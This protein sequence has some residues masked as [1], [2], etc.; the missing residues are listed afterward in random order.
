MMNGHNNQ[1]GNGHI[2]PSIQQGDFDKLSTRSLPIQKA[3]N[4]MDPASLYPPAPDNSGPKFNQQMPGASWPVSGPSMP[5][6][7]SQFL[8]APASINPGQFSNAPVPINPGQFSNA[9]VPINPMSIPQWQG[10]QTTAVSFVDPRQLPSQGQVYSPNIPFAAYED[11][12]LSSQTQTQKNRP[13]II[14]S[15]I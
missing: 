11:I 14:I 8:N 2:D 3:N 6:I 4:Q 7:P 5:G 1:N 13:L 12:S 10:W 9:P 15:A